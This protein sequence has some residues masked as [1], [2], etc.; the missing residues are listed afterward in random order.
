MTPM[1]ANQARAALDKIANHFAP[2][3]CGW[4]DPNVTEAARTSVAQSWITELL[5]WDT[6]IAIAALQEIMAASIHPPTL[7]DL[8]RT[9]RAINLRTQLATPQPPDRTQICTPAEGLTAFTAAYLAE[10]DD[11]TT[12]NR[13]GNRH[14]TRPPNETTL[15]RQQ[16]S[17]I[18]LWAQPHWLDT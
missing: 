2:R 10:C 8:C 13:L 16:Q 5:R 15:E 7:Q 1:P 17:T 3:P 14:P 12:T 6:P 11:P 18:G 9:T 4:T